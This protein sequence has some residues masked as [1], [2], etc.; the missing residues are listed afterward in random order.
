MYG[1][2]Q[3]RLI[4]H[5]RSKVKK[6]FKQYPVRAHG[7]D[8]AVRVSKWA[9]VIARAERADV[10]LSELAALL[11]DIGRVPEELPGNTKRHH[12][13]SYE[14][15]REWFKEDS[16]FGFLS[17]QEKL[18]ILYALRYHWNDAADKYKVAWVLRDADKL[19]AFGKIGLKRSI[20]FFNTDEEK[21][22]HD[23]RLRGEMIINLRSKKARLIIKNKNLLEPIR[24]YFYK[25]LRKQIKPVEL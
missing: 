20:D 24:R 11:H 19:D 9:V 16:V 13:L 17:R 23:L 10:F 1:Q 6:L 5:V 15:C 4:V 21:I 7:F 8:H 25:A 2:E 14:M 22:M 3:D 18:S 12:E